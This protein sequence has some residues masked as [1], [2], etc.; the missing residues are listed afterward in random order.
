M[1]KEQE[2]Q[3]YWDVMHKHQQDDG[4]TYAE[5]VHHLRSATEWAQALLDMGYTPREVERV[6]VETAKGA[7][8]EQKIEMWRQ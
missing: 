4:L 6:M 5:R 7:S 1:T 2:A 8:I 3:L